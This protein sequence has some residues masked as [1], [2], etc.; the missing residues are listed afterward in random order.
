MVP[1]QPPRLSVGVI[2]AGAVGTAVAERLADAGHLITGIVARSVASRQR[3]AERLPNVPI[4]PVEQAAQA[5]L[6]VIAVPDTQLPQVIAQVSQATRDGQIVMHTS[7]AHG[8]EVLQPI[9]DTGAVPLA[10]HPVM[11]FAGW[12]EDA[13]K[14]IGCAWGTTADSDTGEALAELLVASMQGVSVPVPE[15]RRPAYHAAIAYAS[16]YVV[17]LISDAERMLDHALTEDLEDGPPPQRPESARLLQRILPTA[18]DRALEHRM[19]RVTGPVARDDAPAVL[20]HIEAL[21]ELERNSEATNFVGAYHS[22]AERTAQVLGSLEV[23]R[24][25][26]E[27]AMRLR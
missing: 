20:R 15:H 19:E 25:L 22:M 6:V 13:D 16:N 4:V 10:L 17:T 14:L 3:A 9:T 23:E 18:V 2:S 5:A 1:I 24:V 21:K 11:T 12:P 27:L 7:G 8:C 26:S